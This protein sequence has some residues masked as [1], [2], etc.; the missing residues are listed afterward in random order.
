MRLG[1]EIA[2]VFILAVILVGSYI[3][4]Q[5]GWVD[6]ATADKIYNTFVGPQ[7]FSKP[8]PSGTPYLRPT[9]HH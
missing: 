2:A 6:P 7:Q 3:G 4:V 1:N 5:A 8:N 9:M